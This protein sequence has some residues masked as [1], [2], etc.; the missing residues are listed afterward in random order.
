MLPVPTLQA[1]SFAALLLAASVGLAAAP[2]R[3]AEQPN[4]VFILSDD[5][6]YGDLSCYGQQN[7]QTP[8]IDRM[9]AQGL[10]FSQHYSGSTVCAPS[11]A[12]LLTGQHTGRVHQR[13]NGPVR[14]REDPRDVTI[15]TRLKAA[16]YDTAMIGKS[17]LACRSQDGGL[18]GRKGFD[19]FFGFLDHAAAHRYY[20]KHLWR[21][22]AKVAY[23]NNRGKEGED[24]SGDLFLADTLRYLDERAGADRPFFLH[25]AVQ[26]SHADL[27][28]PD[29]WRQKFLGRYDEPRVKKSGNYRYEPNP[30]ATYAAMMAYLDD[31]VGQVL[32][33]LQSLGLAEDTLVLFAS[34][35]GA[36][37]EG[38]WRSEYF[39]SSGPLRGGKRDLYEGGIRTPLIAWWPGT[40]TPGG[41]SDHL[42]A[43]WDFAPTACELAGL[44]PLTAEETDGISY[45][46]TLRGDAA[47]QRQHGLL[48]WEFYERG[49]KQAVRLGGGD[50]R[51][52]GVRLQVGRDRNGPIELYDL[53]ADLGETTDVAAEHPEV[54]QRVSRAMDAAHTPSPIFKFGGQKAKKGIKG[55]RP[56][57]KT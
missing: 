23:P 2:T 1:V 45:A 36:M 52:K 28:V 42:S 40:V 15:A 11:R 32:D 29:A 26:Q 27:Q 18:P 38:H 25:L 4:I 50:S 57:Q 21:N 33:R 30:K 5:V 47:A 41:Q 37:S 9:A 17:G 14:F 10:R 13:G 56:Q 43:F 34:D 7:F 16:G 55:K 31:T 8:R 44:P 53:Q 6:G 20:P 22:G 46:A 12:C 51:W 54:V 35:N 48:Y 24:Y 3:A 39:Q 19:H 49:G